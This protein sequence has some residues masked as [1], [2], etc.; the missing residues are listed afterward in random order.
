[1]FRPVRALIVAVALGP[2]VGCSGGNNVPPESIQLT[3]TTV[4]PADPVEE[5]VALGSVV[6]IVVSSE[7]DG[8][9][10]VHGFEEKVNLVAGETTETSFKASMSGVFEVETHDPDGVWIKLVV[11]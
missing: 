7:V 6:T 3:I 9:L 1:M 11:S 10:H 4:A 5:E 2:L 8:L